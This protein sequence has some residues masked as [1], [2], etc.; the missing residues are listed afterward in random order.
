MNLFSGRRYRG[1]N[2]ALL[3]L[4]MHLRGSALPYWCGFAEAKALGYG[5]VSAVAR[6]TGVSRR[7]IGNGL[8]ELCDPAANRVRQIRQAGG[9]RRCLPHASRLCPCRP[10]PHRLSLTRV[11]QDARVGEVHHREELVEIVLHGRA[12]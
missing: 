7:A 8:K 1:A 4:G 2:P 10:V 12:R 6:A 5:G 11:A 3:T 9:G